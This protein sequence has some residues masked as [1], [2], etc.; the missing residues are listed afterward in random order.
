MSWFTMG[1]PIWIEK[2]R[3]TP[4]HH[5]LP[6]SNH[7]QAPIVLW[8][9]VLDKLRLSFFQCS[10]LA[11]MHLLSTSDICLGFFTPTLVTEPDTELFPHFL[12]Q[13]SKFLIIFPCVYASFVVPLHVILFKHFFYGKDT[14]KQTHCTMV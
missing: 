14:I 12:I 2:N 1:A 13:N 11:Y 8:K 7:E 6:N 10:L 4:L 3:L 5:S 9:A